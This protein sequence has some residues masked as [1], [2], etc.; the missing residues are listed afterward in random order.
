MTAARSLA[1][2]LLIAAAACA[3]A[4]VPAGAHAGFYRVARRDGA[5]WFVAPSGHRF[6]SLGADVV[7]RG[8]ARAKYH[9]DRPE[10]ASFLYY[11]DD[12]A[13][14]KTALE[15]LRAWNFNTL[16][17]WA[18]IEA[19]ERSGAPMLPYTTGI[20]IGSSNGVPWLDLFGP[21]AERGFDDIARR[22]ILPHRADPNLIGYFTDNEL[23]WWEET[24]F[25]FHLKQKDNPTRRV[26]LRLL[27]H[28]YRNDFS[29][30]RR[31]FDT[32]SARRFSDL[33][34]PARFLLKPGG[35][36]R[37][38]VERFT[39]LLARRYY[40]L[41]HDAIRRYDP[42]RLIL[43][44]RYIAWFP[45]VVAEAAR[46]YVDV[47][48]TNYNPD[49]PE[50]GISRFH[51]RNL[52]RLTRRPIMVTEYYACARENRSGNKNPGENYP[53]VE[54]QAERAES[55]RTT[56]REFARLPYLIGAHWFQYYDEP[57]FG[58]P[59]GENFNMGLVDI[60]DQPYEEITAAATSEHAAAQALHQRSG[61][62]APAPAGGPLPA[63]PPRVMDG[64]GGWDRDRAFVAPTTG[65]P[66][67]DLYACWDSSRLYVAM[68]AADIRDLKLYPRGV[69]PDSLR[70]RWELRLGGAKASVRF[71]AGR[72]ASVRGGPADQRVWHTNNRETVL[73]AIPAPALRRGAF[74]PGDTVRLHATFTQRPGQAPA[75]WD[76]VLRLGGTR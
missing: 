30:L 53:T 4:G 43:G 27:R 41:T 31:D 28:H 72:P 73:L 32:G 8:P 2:A 49:W 56:L 69:V 46:P 39:S 59:D 19:L 61:R 24:I 71:G 40:R 29:R 51:F 9:P 22:M 21:Q 62:A 54:T 55:F 37:D 5:W 68:H 75:R 57:T 65:L 60:H 70:L 14:A 26:L 15:R 10:Y 66:E 63:A 44:D 16:G 36:G 64:P 20:W 3:P 52:Y 35:R 58:R 1:I 74:H 6:L 50:G 47:I 13:W 18:D 45:L 33:R 67:A 48:S 42:N 25:I 17:A 34:R 76:R 11:P 38:V 7:D 12:R 23:G